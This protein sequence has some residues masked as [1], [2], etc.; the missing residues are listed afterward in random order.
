MV[1]DFE[2]GLRYASK[3]AAVEQFGLETVPKR[4]DVFTLQD[5]LQQLQSIMDFY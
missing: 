3:T 2:P 4:F 1:A 5:L